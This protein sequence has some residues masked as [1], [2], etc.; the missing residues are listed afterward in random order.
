M[1]S[2]R[3]RRAN[4]ENGKR[5]RG[6]KTK[7]GK[8]RSKQNARRHGLAAAIVLGSPEDRRINE[9]AEAL[10]FGSQFSFHAREAAEAQLILEKTRMLRARLLDEGGDAFG[11]EFARLDRYERR[12]FSARKR[13][14]RRL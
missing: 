5:S 6:P 10:A 14:L 3:E 8:A 12:A 13:A 1:T 9:L 4:R 7:A 11:E 2:D